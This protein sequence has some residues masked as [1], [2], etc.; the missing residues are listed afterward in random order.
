MR[1]DGCVGTVLTGAVNSWSL[2]GLFWGTRF[3]QAARPPPLV[4][5]LGQEGTPSASSL[6][7]TASLTG[8]PPPSHRR[9]SLPSWPHIL[10]NPLR[11]RTHS[12]SA[13]AD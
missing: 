2:R 13:G 4:P 11:V 10:Q 3:L 5:T 7:S 1:R 8:T 6:R 9:Q 12:A